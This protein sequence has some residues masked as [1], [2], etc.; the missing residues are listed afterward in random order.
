MA[1][2]ILL[3]VLFSVSASALQK[4]LLL[5]RAPL[6]TIWT[7]TYGV[8]ALPTLLVVLA[9]HEHL[10]G[11]FWRCIALA[12]I[13]DAL[14]NVAMVAALKTMDLS[15]FGPLNGLRPLIALIFGWA[16][17]GEHPTSSGYLGIILTVAGTGVLMI[18]EK[19]PETRSRAELWKALLLRLLGLALG[20]LAAVY[21]KRAAAI[22]SVGATVAGWTGAGFACLVL[23]SLVFWPAEV[24]SGVKILLHHRSLLT[25]HALVFVSMQWVTIIIFKATL[26]AYAFVFF[27]LAMVLQVIIG[28]LYFREPQFRARFAASLVIT[29]GSILILWKG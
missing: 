28:C 11:E 24:R 22:A 14:G 17:L 26:L 2:L 25:L 27:Q 8:I 29:L 3:R 9:Q 4:R 16:Y 20:V 5:D 15:V 12:G 6:S 18:T 1:L 21:L 23:L 13:I 7:F 10:S 19:R